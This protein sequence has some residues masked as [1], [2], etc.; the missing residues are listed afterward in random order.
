MDRASFLAVDVICYP[1]PVYYLRER[2]TQLYC[3]VIKT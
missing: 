3:I 1:I 2:G